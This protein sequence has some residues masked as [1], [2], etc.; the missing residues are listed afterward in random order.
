MAAAVSVLRQKN[1]VNFKTTVFNIALTGNYVNPTG[2]TI[3]LLASTASNPNGISV[4]GPNIGDTTNPPVV[5]AQ[6]LAGYQAQLA[7]TATPGQYTLTLWNG[8][9]Q[10]ASNPYAT[11]FGATT[12][13]LTIEQDFNLG[14]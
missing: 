3:S 12:P 1:G 5:A 6:S 8:N 13:V 4:T 10:A 14:S 2:E 11:L 7:P 9:S